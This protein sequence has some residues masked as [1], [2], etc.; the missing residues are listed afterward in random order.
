LFPVFLSFSLCRLRKI[1]P[2][3]LLFKWRDSG[4]FLN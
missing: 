2:S 4:T 1:S 3:A